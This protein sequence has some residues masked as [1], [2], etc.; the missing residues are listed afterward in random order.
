LSRR[1]VAIAAAAIAVL[2]LLVAFFV[3]RR[4]RTPQGREAELSEVPLETLDIEG[5]ELRLRLLFPGPSGHLYLEERLVP[6]PTRRVDLVR[7]AVSELFAGP[8][9]PDLVAPF[10][11]E[12]A[13]ADVLLSE[14]GVAY[15]DLA[16]P[17]LSDPPPSGSLTEL[18]EIYSIVDSVLLNAPDIRGV[19]LLWNG[20]QR[21]T[22]AGHL[23]TSRPLRLKRDLI[24]GGV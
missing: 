20:S 5:D 21:P 9:D 11:P 6:P 7:L 3:G 23:D 10:P 8:S 22:F 4:S 2:V 13:V 17:H 15:I 12:V 16:A 24:A 18:L 19:V 1:A 14:E